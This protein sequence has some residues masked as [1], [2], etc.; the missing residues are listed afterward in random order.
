MFDVD[1]NSDTVNYKTNLQWGHSTGRFVLG[2]DA[3]EEHPKLKSVPY[4]QPEKSGT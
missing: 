2:D 4:L 3:D 1:Q